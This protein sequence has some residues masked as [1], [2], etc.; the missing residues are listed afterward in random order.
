MSGIKL[1]TSERSAILQGVSLF[2][3]CTKQELSRIETLT[4]VMDV[5]GGT[6]LTEQGRPGHE[7][8]VIIEGSATAIR[9]GVTLAQ[10]GP[11][12]FFG[13]VALLDG[14]ERTAT[15]TADT[16]MALV[17]M[18]QSEFRTLQSLAPTVARKLLAELGRRLRTADAFL[19]NHAVSG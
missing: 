17:V 2:S 12:S 15:V 9:N 7:F 6:V 16:D 19:D 5:E 18:S 13:E 14:G 4:S 11:G 1:K 8:F 10:L 3:S